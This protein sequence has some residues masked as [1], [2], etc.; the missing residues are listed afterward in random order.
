MLWEWHYWD[1]KNIGWNTMNVKISMLSVSDL[2][3]YIA[4]LLSADDVLADVF[5]EGEI[6]NFKH[7]S[8]G[9]LYFSLKDDD[10]KVNCVMFR[11]AAYYLRFQPKD[12]DSVRIRGRVSVYEKTGVYQ[13]YVNA[14]EKNGIGELY[15]EYTRLLSVLKGKGYFDKTNKK[16]IPFL[17]ERI[18]L[19]TS[20]TGAAVRDM[21]SVITRRCSLTKLIICPVLVQGDNASEQIADMI[22]IVNKNDISDLIILARGGGSIEELWAFN[23]KIVAE[24]IF[25]SVIPVMTGIGH[26]T[27]FTVSDFV[28]DMRAPTPSAAAELAVPDLQDVRFTLDGYKG[29]LIEEIHAAL[30]YN[31]EKLNKIREASFSLSSL[32]ALKEYKRKISDTTKL[33][34]LNARHKTTL[35][36]ARVDSFDKL[37]CSMSFE[38]VL[39]RGFFAIEKDGRIESETNLSMNDNI[40][41]IGEKKRIKSHIDAIEMRE[42]N[43]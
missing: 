32:E 19:I 21:I 18:A 16:Q 9:H 28:A 3:Q 7:H 39:K 38:N 29:M 25:A 20:P 15:E 10:A 8:S 31:K 27:D 43:E 14:M 41:L 2:N 5:V 4:E 40:V 17:P 22:D 26:E 34:G 23:E 11:S 36:R 33:L 30:E 13:V 12:G 6:S 35:Y 24:S 37:V 42:S 1:V